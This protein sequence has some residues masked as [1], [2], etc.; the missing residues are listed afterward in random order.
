MADENADTP[1]GGGN[2]ESREPS[3]EDLVALCRH[4]NQE[5]AVNELQPG[6]VSRYSVVRVADEIVVDLMGS[7]CGIGYREASKDIIHREIDGVRIP[8]A[9]HRLLWKTKARTHREKD[10]ADLAFLRRYFAERGEPPPTM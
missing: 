9:S 10:R 4:L 5:Q 8:F 2:L 1:L 6:E 7:A 3:V